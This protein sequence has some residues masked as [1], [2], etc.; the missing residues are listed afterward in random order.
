MVQMV[1]P[2]LATLALK[3][4]LTASFCALYALGG[5]G[6]KQFRRFVLPAV[7]VALCGLIL[8]LE[9]VVQLAPYVSLLGMFLACN[10]PV[11]YGEKYTHDKTGLKILFRGLCGL[12][13]GLTTSATIYLLHGSLQLIV[14][15]CL[16]AT[17]S[18]IALGVT[19]PFPSKWGNKATITED[20]LIALS[21][22]AVITY[23]L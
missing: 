20:I 8:W 2:L 7:Y 6:I 1:S 21:Y 13:F 4:A 18:S 23:F 16:L 3:V 22:I 10:P 15:N 9:G 12:F 11:S 14:G 19:N 17:V 5:Q